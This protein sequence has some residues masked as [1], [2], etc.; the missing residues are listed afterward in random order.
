VTRLDRFFLF[1]NKV[2]EALASFA[3]S[4]AK[5][6]IH[7]CGGTLRADGPNNG[8]V[9]GGEAGISFTCLEC[10]AKFVAQITDP[11]GPGVREASVLS[12]SIPTYDNEQI[13]IVSPG[14][15]GRGGVLT[16]FQLD[17]TGRLDLFTTEILQKAWLTLPT[18]RR[19]LIG[20]CDVSEVTSAGATALGSLCHD[21]RDRMVML[22]QA[23]EH[24]T[25]SSMVPLRIYATVE[26]ALQALG[27]I[28][29]ESRMPS[30]LSLKDPDS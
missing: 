27:E 24:E 21:A 4:T 2:E 12:I 18:P 30:V 14:A 25:Q 13:R 26:A 20:L 22:R 15:R 1:A 3:P 29:G 19:A 10:S 9:L 23:D 5:C 11:Q 8:P 6:L 28:P 17:V 16:A 7:G